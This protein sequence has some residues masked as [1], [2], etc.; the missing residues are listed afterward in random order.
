MRDLAVG[1]RS[2]LG[3]IRGV[4]RV[5][6]RILGKCG[7]SRQV[8]GGIFR[9]CEAQ[10]WWPGLAIN[11]EPYPGA[12]GVGEHAASLQRLLVPLVQRVLPLGGIELG[13]TGGV[14]FLYLAPDD[15]HGAVYHAVLLGERLG[16][17][18]EGSRQPT[19]RE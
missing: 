19:I 11:R 2:N 14:G 10:P 8:C 5:R 6:G 3:K 1:A 4:H 12:H 18:G 7:T 15:L 16:E 17:D 13:D 9:K